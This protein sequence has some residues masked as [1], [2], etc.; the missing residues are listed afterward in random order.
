MCDFLKKKQHNSVTS[1]K[2]N[3]SIKLVANGGFVS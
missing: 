1:Q 2:Y 3:S